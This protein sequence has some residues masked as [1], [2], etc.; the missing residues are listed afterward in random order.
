MPPHLRNLPPG[1]GNNNPQGDF[2][3]EPQQLG[4]G[5]VAGGGGGGLG[6]GEVG[7]ADSAYVPAPRSSGGGFRDF[8]DSQRDYRQDSNYRN[9]NNRG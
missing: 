9:D 2:G 3:G 1:A 5:N 4:G 7:G 6:A 8:K